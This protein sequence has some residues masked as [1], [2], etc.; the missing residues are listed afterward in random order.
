M[1]PSVPINSNGYF[2]A[3][4]LAKGKN[5]FDPFVALGLFLD[6]IFLTQYGA[7]RYCKRVVIR[8]VFE[9]NSGAA[10]L[11][12]PRVPLTTSPLVS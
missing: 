12:G 7:Q 8:H 6:D 1:E 4:Q 3:E 11:T 10:Q 5:H 2:F 9:R